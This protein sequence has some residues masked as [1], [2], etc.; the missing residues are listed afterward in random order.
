M[1]S[2]YIN[3]D[4]LHMDK[5]KKYWQSMIE[6][7]PLL[8]IILGL[9]ITPTHARNEKAAKKHIK[10]KLW[11]SLYKSFIIDMFLHA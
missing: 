6:A 9:F 2:D 4:E 1:N 7:I 3:P 11:S 8:G 5:W 10:W